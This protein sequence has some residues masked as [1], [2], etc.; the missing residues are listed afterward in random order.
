MPKKSTKSSSKS[1]S[2]KPTQ[3]APADKP[4]LAEDVQQALASVE[5]TK[6]PLHTVSPL[7]SAAPELFDA[8]RLGGL[9]GSVADLPEDEYKVV[10]ANL[11][12]ASIW[13][14]WVDTSKTVPGLYAD[15]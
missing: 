15:V 10:M 11:N 5:I 1:T 6:P 9:L 7:P 2:S 13:N 12:L 4:K 14:S 3:P 8:V